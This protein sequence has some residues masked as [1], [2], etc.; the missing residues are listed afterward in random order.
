MRLVWAT[1]V[2]LNFTHLEERLAFYDSLKKEGDAI[3]IT[4][5]IGEHNSAAKYLKQMHK[6]TALP[7]YFVLGNHDFYGGT[8]YAAYRNIR[9]MTANYP[10]IV[11]LRDIKEPLW[12]TEDTILCGVDGWADGRYGDYAHSPVRLNDSVYIKELAV[13]RHSSLLLE[14]MQ[15]LAD[16]D[17]TI[18]NRQLKAAVKLAP[19]QILIASHIPPYDFM[20]TYRGEA[21]HPYF[22]PFYSSKALSDVITPFLDAHP[23]I[24]FKIIAGHTHGELRV[25][26][27]PHVTAM[28]GGAEYYRPQINNVFEV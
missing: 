2:H 10:Q 24:L 7:V 16:R 1:D 14:E 19:K 27:K 5:D 21:S 28:V 11:W 3:L 25:Q 18:L 13:A 9:Y 26:F 6:C 20:S 8:V 12:L 4:G 22:M 15:R 23:T 17:A